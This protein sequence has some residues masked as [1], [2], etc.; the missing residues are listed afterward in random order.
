MSITD[1][2]IIE[3]KNELKEW[4]E[5]PDREEEDYHRNIQKIKEELDFEKIRKS[6][7]LPFEYLDNWYSNNFVYELL[8]SDSTAYKVLAVAN[9]YYNIVIADTLANLYT[10]RPPNLTFDKVAYWLAN[11]LSQKRYKESEKLL[12]IINKSLSTDILKGGLDYKPASWFILEITNEGY[13][14]NLDYEEFNY[15]EDIGVYKE[16]LDNWDT[17]DLSKLDSIITKLCEFHL[18]EA[19]YGDLGENAGF[20]DPMFLQF[21]DT[22]WFVY[23]FE[24]LAWLS[25]RELKGLKNSEKF[26]HPLM[27]LPINKLSNELSPFPKNELTTLFEKVIKRLS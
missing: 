12:T 20:K 18:Q 25:I 13:G 8:N 1:S 17:T 19:S 2:K 14:I 27:S 6:I 3:T 15:P 9:G 16:A 10:N 26:S 22:K 23:A 21:S 11:C 24:I 7:R 4:L 5:K